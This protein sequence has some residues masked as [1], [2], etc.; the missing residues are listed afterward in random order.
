[1][2]WFKRQNVQTP[3]FDP[4]GP[5]PWYL[6]GR[7]IETKA[8][9]LTWSDFGNHR[10]LAGV[11]RLQT[12]EAEDVMLL[13]FGCYVCP[14]GNDRLLLWYERARNNDNPIANPIIHFDIVDLCNLVPI[15][16]SET[17]SERMR[18]E[19]QHRFFLPIPHPEF[20]CFSTIAPGRHDLTGIP[21]AFAEI[22]ETL[23][24]A[25]CCP[26]GKPSNHFD[27]MSRAIF[28]FDFRS[29]QVDVL[30]QEW[31]NNGNYDF[32]YQWITRVSRDSNTGRIFG[33]GIRL[34][35]FRLNETGRS[36]EEWL[37]NDPFHGPRG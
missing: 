36:V 16:A 15:T 10:V 14:L 13:D 9:V 28:A 17:E 20:T 5:S 21:P 31:F 35:F 24:L 3:K 7:K 1:M 33:E 34:G 22:E 11:S 37:V 25:D 19:K 18:N 27:Q 6:H 26:E 23:V 8:G 2:K 30:P 4:P 32:G 29:A 12:S